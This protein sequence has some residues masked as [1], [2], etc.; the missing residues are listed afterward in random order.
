MES[1]AITSRGQTTV[2]AKVRAALGLKPGDKVRYLILENG[3]VYL[4]RSRSVQELK[5]L[6]HR[7]GQKP[8]TLEEIDDAIAKGA[9]ASL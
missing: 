5:G 7:P 6:L 3:D 4:Q 2:P 8:M 9:A 1:S